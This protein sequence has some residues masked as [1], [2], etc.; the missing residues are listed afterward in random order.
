MTLDQLIRM[1]SKNGRRTVS[2]VVGGSQMGIDGQA[3]VFATN[4]ETHQLFGTTDL[5]RGK[6]TVAVVETASVKGLW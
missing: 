1:E 2:V 6:N 3:V 5:K 4:S